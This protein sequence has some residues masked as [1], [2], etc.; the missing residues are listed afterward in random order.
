MDSETAETVVETF[1]RNVDTNTLREAWIT[2]SDVHLLAWLLDE[3]AKAASQDVGSAYE[4]ARTTSGATLSAYDSAL[5]TALAAYDAACAATHCAGLYEEADHDA[6][7]D[8]E[9]DADDQIRWLATAD[10]IAGWLGVDPD[11]PCA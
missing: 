10:Q 4:V 7:Q 8:D 6:C 5:A 3:A 1:C 9:P 11:E 2:C